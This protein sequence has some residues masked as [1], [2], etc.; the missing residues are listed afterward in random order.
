MAWEISISS[1][2]WT[3]I[4]EQLETWDKEDLITAITDDKFEMVLA[5]ADEHHAKRAADAEKNRLSDVPHDTLVDLAYELVEQNCTCDNGGWA[6][7]VD[8]EGFHKVQLPDDDDLD[9]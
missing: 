6:Y 4:R 7:W 3:E 2:G 9:E 1:D 8:R 5:K